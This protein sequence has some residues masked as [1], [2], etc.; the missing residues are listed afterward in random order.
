MPLYRSRTP[1]PAFHE[2]ALL[3]LAAVWLAREW[4][5]W[6]VSPGDWLVLSFAGIVGYSEYANAGYKEAQNLLFDLIAA[7]VLPYALAKGLLRTTE[8]RVAFAKRVVTLLAA[9]T[10]LM[11][12]EFRFAYNPYRFL[13][14]KFFPGQGDGW[15]TT[16]RYGFARSAG[17]YGHAILAGIVFLIGFHLQRWLENSGRWEP[18]FR[19]FRLP[20]LGK[21]RALSALLIGG[22]VM[23]MVRGPQIGA[24]SRPWW[25][26]SGPV[27]TLVAGRGGGL[28]ALAVGIPAGIAAYSYASVG[29][30]RRRTASQESAAYRKELIDKYV[31]VALDHALL[32]WAGTVG[33]R[34]RECL[35]RQLLLT[36][37][38]HAWGGGDTALG[39]PA[40]R[41]DDPAAA[42]RDTV[43]HAAAQGK[44]TQ[45]PAGW[46][47]RRL[48]VRG[49]YRVH[50]GQ[51]HPDLLYP[52]GLRG[53]ISGGGRRSLPGSSA[54]R[55]TGVGGFC[56]APAVCRDSELTVFP[57]GCSGSRQGL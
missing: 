41:H 45:L 13:F 2:S 32:G 12:W 44:L 37:I 9:L 40:R 22:L 23:T 39:R 52:G 19:R 36:A 56:L 53:G 18:H 29:R 47:L 1:D 30:A 10:L 8:H 17:P 48:L 57:G 54:G 27:L 28:T 46:N 33:Q 15:V 35:D 20:G 16:F 38:A 5:Q 3:P 25:P 50:G 14:D 49:S 31:D 55:A 4:K 11:A 21:G 43:G 24:P 6:R 7:G 51:R 42:Q 34:W 26:P